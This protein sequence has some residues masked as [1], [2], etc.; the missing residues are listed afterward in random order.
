MK[1]SDLPG[2]FVL[3]ILFAQLAYTVFPYFGG[4]LHIANDYVDVPEETLINGAYVNNLDYVKSLNAMRASVD[5]SLKSTAFLKKNRSELVWQSQCGWFM[6]HHNALLASI[7]EYSLGKKLSLINRQYG[8][9]NVIGL[10]YLLKLT[11]GVTFQNYC[12][13]LYSFYPLY[14]LLLLALCFLLTRKTYFVL[15]VAVLSLACLNMLGYLN[16]NLAPGFNPIRQFGCIFVVASLFLYL[17]NRKVVYLILLV[18]SSAFSILSNTEFGF[19]T[20]VALV[21]TLLLKIFLERE[22]PHGREIVGILLICVTAGLIGLFE[23]R[24]NPTNQY[25]LKGISGPLMESTKWS[26]ILCPISLFYVFLVKA[27]NTRHNLRYVASFLFF[28]SQGILFYYVWN[29][30]PNHFYSIATPF[31]LTLA[32][33]LKIWIDETRMIRYEKWIFALLSF[34][35]L[36]SIYLPSLQGYYPE[37]QQYEKIFEDH[38]VY[39]WSLPRAKF[40]STMDPRLFSESTSLIKK[41]SA[42]VRAIYIISKYDNLLPFLA[43]SYSAMPYSELAINL[44]TSNEVQISIAAILKARPPYIFVDSD[45]DAVF[46]HSPL[47]IFASKHFDFTSKTDMLGQLRVVFNAV[48]PLYR[49]IETSGFLTVYKRR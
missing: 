2:I 37:R 26:L 13:I 16:I 28:Y 48:K 46:A 5:K 42:G 18:L 41:Y 30:V 22:L 7:N 21:I 9:L 20:F 6:H 11:G 47:Y 1:K 43:E 14:F 17:S 40:Y 38:R 36:V 19:F 10:S 45:I 12:R 32:V 35:C 15:F 49:P 39:S 25:Y 8:L 23:A 31:V 4:N 24:G 3:A 29:S 44:L 27:L 34:I 33:F